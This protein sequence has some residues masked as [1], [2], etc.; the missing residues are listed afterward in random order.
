MLLAAALFTAVP[1]ASAQAAELFW[2]ACAEGGIKE[3]KTA[4]LVAP[5]KLPRAVRARLGTPSK[6]EGW[7]FSDRPGATLAIASYEKGGDV[8]ERCAV[9][10]KKGIVEDLLSDI[11]A[12]YRGTDLSGPVEPGAAIIHMV[13][14]DQENGWVMVF[15]K[16]GDGAMVEAMRLDTT[17]PEYD[18]AYRR[19]VTSAQNEVGPVR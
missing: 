14:P 19:V 13:I 9:V 12:R 7:R 6:V 11:Y 3:A 4:S 1:S 18:A 17:S 8:A 10:S 2:Q 15:R 16:T 5:A